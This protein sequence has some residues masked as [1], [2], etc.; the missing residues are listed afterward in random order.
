MKRN[1]I[2]KQILM[3]GVLLCAMTILLGVPSHA[4]Q[5]SGMVPPGMEDSASPFPGGAH[6][7]KTF[8]G[9]PGAADKPAA[10][11]TPGEVRGVARYPNGLP[12]PGAGGVI[13][14]GDVN[15]DR[16]VLSGTD[17][18]F[19]FTN[20]KPG[21]YQLTAKKEGFGLS[22]TTKVVLAYGKIVT[23]DVPLG[24]S[25]AVSPA[26]TNP[27]GFLR[28]Y[29]QS[30]YQVQPASLHLTPAQPT[31]AQPPPAPTKPATD[32]QNPAATTAEQPLPAAVMDEIMA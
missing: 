20:L 21:E 24:P 17:G 7:P 29:N 25:L 8:G 27:A 32:A 3:A 19:V 22:P 23:V 16:T 13:P 5:A 26:N 18:A 30:T 15:I 31:I 12:M 28:P 10:S 2:C 1:L 14:H 6:G 11:S 9:N 4:Q